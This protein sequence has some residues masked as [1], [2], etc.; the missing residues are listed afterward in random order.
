[1]CHRGASAPPGQ[2]AFAGR[3]PLTL[4]LSGEHWPVMILYEHLATEVISRM[5]TISSLDKLDFE[6][7]PLCVHTLFRLVAR[8][9]PVDGKTPPFFLCF[10]FSPKQIDI[11][12]A[13]FK[14]AKGPVA[15]GPRINLEG[16]QQQTNIEQMTYRLITYVANGL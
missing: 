7:V 2:C 3:L 13:H 8:A 4:G 12:F 14:V 6:Y 1:M 15:T 16:A 9:P 10:C 5:M 11:L